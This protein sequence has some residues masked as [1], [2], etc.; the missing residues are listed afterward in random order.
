M[1]DSY[2]Q[3]FLERYL[4]KGGYES[5]GN[6]PFFCPF[7]SH[8]KKKLQIK[9]DPHSP[10]FG[11]W[12][13]WVCNKGGKS[14]ETLLHAMKI[15]NT[16]IKSIG[17]YVNTFIHKNK[18]KIKI[19][20]SES[21]FLS[22]PK[23]FKSLYLK[24]TKN[25]EYR[26]AIYYILKK[27]KISPIEILRYNIGYCETGRFA[28]RIIIPSYDNIGNLNYFTARSYYEDDPIPYL[29]VNLSKDIIG[30]DLFINW[31]LPISL[32]EGPFDAI[33]YRRNAIP[34]FGKQI[35][36][37]LKMK[38]ITEKVKNIYIGLDPDAI[39]D[40]IKIIEEFYRQGL[41]VYFLQMTGENDAAKEGYKKLMEITNNSIKIK[42]SDIIKMKLK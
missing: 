25:P 14:I 9:L 42:F 3:Q 37:K 8:R 27:R 18:D 35:S 16:I 34:L 38:I 7:C 28:N 39:K 29:N 30:F 5:N 40:S 33:A 20:K 31:K 24:E 23:E 1:I 10:S 11:A 19:D 41:N 22:L 17:E 15:D 32:F 21:T 6:I 36:E 26:N 4:G 2:S 13:C 12:H